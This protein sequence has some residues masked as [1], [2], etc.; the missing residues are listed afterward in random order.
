MKF[1]M[2]LA[3]VLAAL[4]LAPAFCSAQVTL[5]ID[6]VSVLPG[7]NVNV[8]INATGVFASVDIPLDIGADGLGLPTGLTLVPGFASTP[9]FTFPTLVTNSPLQDA[10]VSG[11][12]FPIAA[13]PAG[14][15]F[16]FQFNVGSGVA[17]GTVFDID[18]LN[19]T[20]FV[21]G[22]IDFQ[23]IPAEDITIT[24]GSI[25]VVA[26]DSVPGSDSVPEPSSLTLLLACGG[27]LMSRRR[28]SN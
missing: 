4:I 20:N 26:P 18:I 25:T 8:G 14:Q 28:R 17:P 9:P 24:N 12:N 2:K 22:G 23:A 7:Q 15:I 6:D 21:I 10:L 19:A 1:S 3:A 5:D 13:V 27:Y 16:E 11:S